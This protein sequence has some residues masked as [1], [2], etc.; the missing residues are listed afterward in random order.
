MFDWLKILVPAPKKPASAKPQ[1]QNLVRID[2]R[3]YPLVE[4][5][6]ERFLAGGLDASLAHGQ[7]AL[8]TVLV[9]DRWG[10]FT[11]DCRI[12]IA[13]AKDGK[14]FSGTWTLLP[15]EVEAVVVQYAKLRRAARHK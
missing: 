11:F 14:H 1:P 2:S 6:R 9:K 4:L 7:R 12:E 3:Q 5:T 15:P 10:N 13:F 8:V